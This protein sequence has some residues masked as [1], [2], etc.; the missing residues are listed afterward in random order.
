[1]TH[2]TTA[3]EMTTIKRYPAEIIKFFQDNYPEYPQYSE[4]LLEFQQSLFDNAAPHTLLAIAHIGNQC[5]LEIACLEYVRRTYYPEQSIHMVLLG[6]GHLSLKLEA[7]FELLP[8]R[9][10]Q[11]LDDLNSIQ[12]VDILG[13]QRLK[14][15]DGKLLLDRYAHESTND[16]IEL[17]KLSA[18]KI[19]GWQLSPDVNISEINAEFVQLMASSCQPYANIFLP[20]Q[21]DKTLLQSRY[22]QFMTGN[23]INENS[24]S[25]HL[26][27][28]DIESSIA[29]IGGGLASVNLALSLAER[30]KP[31]EFFCKDNSVAQGASGN[32]QGGL[33]PLLTPENDL[34]SQY[35]QQ[36]FLFC[37]QRISSLHQ[38]GFSIA[39][40]FCGVVQ[41]G[42]EERS[43]ARLQK[44]VNGNDWP[45]QI[46]QSISADKA[47]EISGVSIDKDS[48]YYPLAGWVC[49]ADFARAALNKASVLTEVNTHFNTQIVKLE[50]T[51]QGWILHSDNQSYGPY[52]KV[53]NASGYG[54]TGFE[55]TRHLPASLFRGQV[56]HIP[57]NNELSKLKTVI[58]AH[59]YLTPSHNQHHCLGASYIKGAENIHYSELEQQQN[60]Q[61]MEESYPDR[62]WV[63]SIDVS[64]QDARVGV[65]LVTRD[66]FPMLGLAPN[67]EAIQQLE[68][69]QPFKRK[70]QVADY[71]QNMPLPVF[72]GL[73]ILGALGSRGLCSGPL[74][75][76]ALAA[77]L[78]NELP[79]VSP[80]L[81]EKV[82][83]NRLW[84]RKLI[85]GR[86]LN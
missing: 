56:S 73:Y 33:Y 84:K 36:A 40:D 8:P 34:L 78:C 30:G 29:I 74:A 37:R 1:M 16:F 32:K 12:W 59:G 72:N 26:Q 39:H 25:T 80:T 23:S 31:I 81:F 11:V 52:Q 55:Q 66:H 45:Q 70:Q 28:A 43:T 9:L 19:D 42:H 51:P 44:I 24:T 69:E 5:S 18:T 35:F 82:N 83:P 71:W 50:Q 60:K 41:S 20:N 68:A 17:C 7:E 48:L 63:N 62:E 76:E 46:L 77:V 6:S 58:C 13:C 3:G 64:E 79:P 14:F 49:P 38:Q 86:P 2:Q 67:F 47:N 65:R 75:A 15:D 85:K 57:S 21:T 61:R 53:I 22:L 4:Q 27:N 54:L 10:Q